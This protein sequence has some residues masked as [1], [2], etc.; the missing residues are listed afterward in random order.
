MSYFR[1]YARNKHLYDRI[2][3]ISTMVCDFCGKEGIRIRHLTRS[4][5]QGSSLLVIENVPVITCHNCGES[6]MTADTLHEIQ[7]IKMHRESM[8]QQKRVSVV[9]FAQAG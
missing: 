9:T 8:A 2:L 1:S 4:Y 3:R 7:R 6:Y 5:G